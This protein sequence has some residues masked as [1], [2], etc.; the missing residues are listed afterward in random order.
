MAKSQAML[1]SI[2]DEDKKVTADD[3]KVNA[4]STGSI[5]FRA[6]SLHHAQF[7]SA[8]R[9]FARA[10]GRHSIRGIE[11]GKHSVNLSVLVVVLVA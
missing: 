3:G 11:A 8:N 9:R 1:Q 4:R 10:R 6:R 5:F 2:V 7:M